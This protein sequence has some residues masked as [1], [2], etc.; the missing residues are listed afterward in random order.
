MCILSRPQ[1]ERADISWEETAQGLSSGSFPVE[2]E[3]KVHIG[4]DTPLAFAF[5]VSVWVSLPADATPLLAGTI[6]AS[7]PW[8]TLT[9]RPESVR[10]GLSIAEPILDEPVAATS[11]EYPRGGL[12][13][14]SSETSAST[15]PA[16]T[17]LASKTRQW[18]WGDD[19]ADSA[20]L[21]P[22]NDL[23]RPTTSL[24]RFSSFKSAHFDFGG[25]RAQSAEQVSVFI[26]KQLNETRAAIASA[27][28]DHL[29]VDVALYLLHKAQSIE[30]N[31]GMVIEETGKRRTVGGIFIK[32]LRESVE[33]DREQAQAA[34]IHIKKDG[35]AAKKAR[36]Q[37]KYLRRKAGERSPAAKQQDKR[38]H[39]PT[40]IDHRPVSKRKEELFCG[41]PA[42]LVNEFSTA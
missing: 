19:E 23:R 18:S 7:H 38:V 10:F 32:L 9:L 28:V 27:V 37:G 33:L 3:V 2:E 42:N 13:E 34:W 5:E 21:P 11:A 29:G 35:D 17:T 31:G 4:M 20:D 12:T 6:S 41:I 15:T 8:L 40:S 16:S 30:A 39:T 25:A 22:L 26:L 24:P 14:P 1:A 36:V